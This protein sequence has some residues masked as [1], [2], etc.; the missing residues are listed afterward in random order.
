[1][2][3]LTRSDREGPFAT[4]TADAY[5]DRGLVRDAERSRARTSLDTPRDRDD[6][7]YVASP[8]ARTSDARAARRE[9]AVTARRRRLARGAR[10]APGRHRRPRRGRGRGAAARGACGLRHCQPPD[11]G[12]RRGE[13]P[14][15]D[16]TSHR[17]R[18]SRCVSRWCR[19]RRTAQPRYVSL[20][21]RGERPTRSCV[22]GELR[23]ARVRRDAL[24]QRR[25]ASF[26]AGRRP[27]DS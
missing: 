7:A 2:R 23:A 27:S 21:A 13:P 14:P 22:A 16:G 24:R 18:V 5:F 9:D 15:G 3:S 10:V 4:G 17:R 1:M 19:A 26:R 6:A 11:G 12:P 8:W 25:L 20:R